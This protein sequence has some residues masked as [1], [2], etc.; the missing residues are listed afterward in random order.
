VPQVAVCEGLFTTDDEGTVRLIGGR[1]TTC[2]RHSFP[3]GAVCPWCGAMP[4]DQVLLSAT[5]T[6]WG[7]TT[8]G[9]APPGYRGPVPFGFGVVELAD[10]IRIVTRLAAADIS[11]LVFGMPM[12]LTTDVVD[13]DDEGNEVVTWSFRPEDER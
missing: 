3:V 2:H 7:F 12:R 11:A 5:G 13:L 10:G 6:L 8:I 9:T 1:C 4:V